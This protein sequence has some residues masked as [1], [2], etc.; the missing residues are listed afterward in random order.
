MKRYVSVVYVCIACDAPISFVPE[1][2]FPLDEFDTTPPSFTKETKG[3]LNGAT[4]NGSVD[5]TAIVK[6]SPTLIIGSI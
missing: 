2:L 1:E 3:K 4:A 5:D 6:T